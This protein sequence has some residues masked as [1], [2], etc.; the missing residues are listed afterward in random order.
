MGPCGGIY[1]V[2]PQTSEPDHRALLVVGRKTAEPG[3]ISR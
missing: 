3:Y 2:G 1:Q